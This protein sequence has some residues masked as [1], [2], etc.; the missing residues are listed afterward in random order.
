[1]FYQRISDARC[2]RLAIL[3]CFTATLFAS[4]CVTPTYAQESADIL[5]TGGHVFD[6]ES[7]TFKANT[8]ITVSKGRF[9]KVGADKGSAAK[10]KI[11]LKD[12]QDI[13]PGLIDCHAH[14]NMTLFRKRREELKYMPLIYLANGATVT[15]SCGE[16]DPEGMLK[17]R[18]RIEAGEQIGP[19]L[20]TSG[21]YFGRVRPGWRRDKPEQEIRDEVD[22]WAK[23]GSAGFKAKAIDPDSL[24]VLIDQAH[25]H[26]LTVTGHLDSGFRGCVNPRDAITMGIDRIEHFLGGDAMPASQSAY[27]SLKDIKSGT[28]AFEKICKH[29]IDN[30]V[31]FDC[32]LSAYG[33]LGETT[34][35]THEE[36]EYWI[37]ERE[38]FTP[39]VQEI[40]KKRKPRKGMELY[41]AVYRAKQT[42]IADFH[43]AG[44]T[45]TLGTDHNSNGNHLPGFGVH[46]EL[47]AL[48]RNGIPAA[49]AI[50]IATINGA[51]A[52]RIEKDYGSIEA[53]KVAD[54]VIIEGNPIEK[55]RNT[56]NVQQVMRAG[57]IHDPKKLFEMAKGKIG[58]AS[59]DEEKDW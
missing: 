47:D 34:P 36:Y 15:F 31:F 24:R 21:P 6:T 54:L 52:F 32:T 39:H 8:G 14:Y 56:R 2:P 43:Q 49:D 29:F 35:E 19:K 42:T 13:L 27:R 38:F 1:M 16:Y 26:D 3:V 12:S 23:Q 18:K 46:R 20:L 9:V 59:A 58:P 53:G 28:P 33:Y 55:I 44:G 45:I 22:F 37:D 51:R 4:F 10:E 7:G 41:Q 40:V 57:K 17:L 25:K 30:D 48:V 11:Q 5:I 50:K